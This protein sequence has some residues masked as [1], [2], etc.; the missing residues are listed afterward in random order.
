MNEPDRVQ[1]KPEGVLKISLF[2]Q[3]LL[4]LAVKMI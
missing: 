3:K 1:E 4:T 2:M